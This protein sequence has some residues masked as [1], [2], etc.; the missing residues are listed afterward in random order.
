[1][2]GFL[3]SSLNTIKIME[4]PRVLI[5]LQQTQWQNKLKSDVLISAAINFSVDVKC[6]FCLQR[7]TREIMGQTLQTSCRKYYLLI[8]QAV[9]GFSTFRVTE[10]SVLIIKSKENSPYL[11]VWDQHDSP[12]AGILR[13]LAMAASKFLLL[14]VT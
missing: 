1:M 9:S 7:A 11:L 2:S 10:K 4:F 6:L 12:T 5:L 13:R 8:Y 3:P 14:Q